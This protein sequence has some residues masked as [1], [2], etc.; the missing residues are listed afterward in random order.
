MTIEIIVSLI[1]ALG[2][3]G[4]IGVVLNR[5]FE[6]Q[7]QTN[8]HD[9]KIFKQS[10]EILTEQKL[11]GI[12]NFHLLSNH[13]IADD[14]FFQIT[15]WC[16]FFGETG[17]KF[18]DKGIAKENQK[19]LNDLNQLANFIGFNFFTIRG[20]NS[21][22]NNQYLK[23]DWNPSRGDDPSPEKIARYDEYANE[24]EDLTKKSIKQYS[25]YRLAIKRILKI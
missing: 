18:L 23:P 12:T 3:G 25:E 1:A 16:R 22:N 19:L 13:S 15:K 17:N 5:R 7:K 8:E 4:I 14:D 10:N 24:L 21:S 11:S 9:I 20:Q 2:V 6:Q